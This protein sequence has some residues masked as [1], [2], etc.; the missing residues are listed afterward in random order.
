MDVLYL[1]TT[2]LMQQIHQGLAHLE[3]SRESKTVSELEIFLRQQLELADG[4]CKRLGL[5]A[6]K[7]P[8]NRRRHAQQLVDQLYYDLNQANG[9]FEKII[10]RFQEFKRCELE[11]EELLSR[12][13]KANETTSIYMD[14][15]A[16]VHNEKLHS[17][18][19]YVDEM[20]LSGQSILENLRF[21][22][23]SMKNIRKRLID[24][25]FLKMAENL[26]SN[27]RKL[28]INFGKMTISPEIL[29]DWLSELYSFNRRR[30]E[31][32]ATEGL[33]SF[34]TR[35]TVEFLFAV[36]DE[37]QLMHELRYTACTIFDI[38]ISRL[39]NSLWLYI[40]DRC[41]SKE[42]LLEDWQLITE[43][44][45]KGMILRI[46]SCV[47]VAS[48]LEC[49]PEFVTVSKAKQFL[50]KFGLVYSNE[51]IL[52]SELRVAKTLKYFLQIPS[53]M[54]YTETLL[55][56]LNLLD[57][58][59]E[60]EQ[61]RE[62]IQD[63]LDL[64]W[65]MRDEIY[66]CI[67]SYS[68]ADLLYVEND[69]MYLAAGVIVT[70]VALV[71]NLNEARKIS[72][73]LSEIVRVEADD[74]CRFCQT[75]IH[76]LFDKKYSLTVRDCAMLSIV[77]SFVKFVFFT[78]IGGG[79]G[80]FFWETAGKNIDFGDPKFN[81][82]IH[83]F[84]V[85]S[86]A[87]SCGFIQMV[88]SVILMTLVTILNVHGQAFIQCALM[89]LVADSPGQNLMMNFHQATDSLLC[90][91]DVAK[92]ITRAKMDLLFKPSEN[93]LDDLLQGAKAASKVSQDL[94]L[95]VQDLEAELGRD[96]NGAADRE[97]EAYEKDVNEWESAYLLKKG[98]L[99]SK[100]EAMFEH[101]VNERKLR[102]LSYRKEA[103]RNFIRRATH[104]CEDI[105]NSAIRE[106]KLWSLEHYNKCWAENWLNPF[107]KIY[108]GDELCNMLNMI[109]YRGEQ[110]ESNNS[111]ISE[112]ANTYGAQLAAAEDYT[113]KLS[114]DFKL[115]IQ[116]KVDLPLRRP[117]LVTVQQMAAII[118]QS[119][120]GIVSFVKYFS[121][122]MKAVSFFLALTTLR[123]NLS[124][125]Q[126][127][128]KDV[129]HSNCYLTKFWL[130]IEKRRKEENRKHL[131]P[132][133]PFEQGR[134]NNLLSPKPTPE[135]RKHLVRGISTLFHMFWSIFSLI[136][137]DDQFYHLLNMVKDYSGIEVNQT[138]KHDIIITLE[139]TGEVARMIG[140]VIEDLNQTVRLD[141][142]IT[143]D[144]CIVQPTKIDYE[145]VKK[146][147]LLYALLCFQLTAGVYLVRLRLLITNLMYP[148]RE[149]VRA[150]WLYNDMLRNRAMHF[151]KRKIE[152]N[153][154]AMDDEFPKPTSS[155]WSDV[156]VCIYCGEKG[157]YDFSTCDKHNQNVD[158]CKHC[159]EEELA[160]RCIA[161]LLQRENIL[162]K[163]GR[164]KEEYRA[165]SVAEASTNT[166][167]N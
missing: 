116:F 54:C 157:K 142:V 115:N 86:F 49:E 5:I 39:V 26:I 94:P 93:I 91:I 65:L 3:S 34:L 74:I 9:A 76:L 20:I 162:G 55:K 125:F 151:R 71:K 117:D 147:W 141:Q 83:W 81:V 150:V 119:V 133:R 131:M 36:C 163:D 31:A 17:T 96:P 149:K 53:P 109:N 105:I 164:I 114:D 121:I 110:C 108:Q 41:E 80:Y 139:G 167:R 101:R 57:Q 140:S 104:A 111:G 95:M 99:P 156:F 51:Q 8:V 126:S 45:E 47:Q 155:V 25:A 107:C 38:F 28:R 40:R 77:K 144:H 50:K 97:H 90:N 24:Y 159:W 127:Y 130:D 13:Y 124:W 78:T 42:K 56:V 27:G 120:S 138:G 113:E 52:K 46:I 92:N 70:A 161:C 165:L 106:C 30:M 67:L 23:F 143:N 19:R 136:I 118:K 85:F 22:A 11:R 87:L 37:M 66:K 29:Q 48:K 32:A 61:F 98:E 58:R 84:V 148:E 145:S 35:Q 16:L 69:F 82:W 135:E 68:I 75:I 100:I 89:A 33:C 62:C 129:T 166:E 60:I 122:L 21:Q 134:I 152:I 128:M 153:K 137:I 7:Q 72:E 6:S 158:H 160:E 2:N 12:R 63:L 123:V 79:I 15:A 10:L 1:E 59:F 103:L 14:D 88:R 18:N 132:L 112:Y 146:I 64:V 43:K 102:E 44:L 73:I 154:M 4:N